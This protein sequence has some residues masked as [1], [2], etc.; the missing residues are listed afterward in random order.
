M[1]VG[2][3]A[4]LEGDAGVGEN[5]PCLGHQGSQG[6]GAEAGVGVRSLKGGDGGRRVA[7]DLAVDVS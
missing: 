5:L 4:A 3:V 7:D 2:V 1:V 6:G